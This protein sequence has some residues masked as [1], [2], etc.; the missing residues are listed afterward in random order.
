MSK[1]FE[2][3][4]DAVDLL[5]E[6]NPIEATMM[7]QIKCPDNWPDLS[8]DGYRS[9][10]QRFG[11]LLAEVKAAEPEG[12]ADVVARKVFVE[13]AE[14]LI[15]WIDQENWAWD[16]NNLA[17]PFQGLTQI[18]SLLPTE[19]E[20]DWASVAHLLETIEAP[21]GGYRECLAH[22]LATGVTPARRQVEAVLEQGTVLTGDDS[23]LRALAAS[24]AIGDISGRV[25]AAADHAI[26]AIADF[27]AWLGADL[28]P[29]AQ[30]TDAVGPERYAAAVWN[31]LQATIDFDEAYAWGWSEIATLTSRLGELCAE[32]DP[33]ASVPEVLE[34]LKTDPERCAHSADEF[35]SVMLERQL[36]ALSSLS[37][38][39]F[40]VPE[41]IRTIEVKSPPDGGATAPHYTPPSADFSRAGTVWYP[42]YGRTQF[43]LYGE[44]TT[45]Y[46]EGFPGHH[47]QI[48]FQMT[49]GDSLSR[50]HRSVVWTPG[51]GEGW[52]L[53]AERLMGELGYLEKPD[54]EIGLVTSQLFRACRVVIDIGS[55]LELPIP[56][57]A[58][59]N[60]EG[61][62]SF[63][64]AVEMLRTVSYMGE[65]DSTSEI[66]RYLGW[67]GQA[68][69]YKWGEKVIVDLRDEMES[70]PGFD[71]KTFHSDLLSAGSVGLDLL[72]ELVR[73]A[74]A[75]R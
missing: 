17:S 39:H 70:R 16:L 53:Y 74:Q 9:A 73:D 71:L 24:C 62:W 68:I 3:S 67:P 13:W 26:G 42:I 50:L 5:I 49:L 58:P 10:A 1:I 11:Q 32:I 60:P 4:S 47:L 19:T 34:L 2:L 48:G 38:T 43:P 27:T 57:D 25:V 29:A 56:D 37:G 52:A 33:E 12:P 59:V 51:S 30:A 22:G 20:A 28:L 54:Y 31:H 64:T 18:F 63:D 44:V 14:N 69:S 41:P 6:T 15:G 72:V 35:R 55:H 46:H 45:A 36:T 7:G 8:P 66:T 23:P 21:F 61:Q 75:A 40:D 65:A